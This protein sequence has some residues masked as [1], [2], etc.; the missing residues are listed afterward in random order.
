MFTRS[1]KTLL[2]LA[3]LL[4]GLT[5]LP[6]AAQFSES[7]TFL[8]AVRDGD[9]SKATD[10]LNRPG[11]T[12]VNTRD[13]TT[14]QTALHIVVDQRNTTWLRFLLQKGANPNLRDKDGLTPLMLAAS[15]RYV[16]GAQYLL[17]GGAKVD[18]DNSSGETP[19]IRAVQLRDIEM[20]QLLLDKGADPDRTDSIAGR[21]AR[22]YAEIAR[23]DPRTRAILDA[24]AARD[25]D[26]G[27]KGQAVFGPSL[28]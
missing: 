18:D 3:A 19:L 5:T 6:A 17:E 4:I 11:T 14:G 21:S 27:E 28:R 12:I 25:Q 20:V 9:G 8:K 7:Y 23:E 2:A 22:Q 1:L 15:L 24:M 26:G 13:V 16:E 10:L